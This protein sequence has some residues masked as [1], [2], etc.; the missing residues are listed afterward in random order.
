M[1]YNW[2]RGS[3]GVI[4]RRVDTSRA[5]PPADKFKKK[6]TITPATDHR[7][8]LCPPTDAGQH[9]LRFADD[10]R[11][12]FALQTA[13][14][15]GLRCRRH[16]RQGALG[17]GA[18]QADRSPAA[19]FG[20]LHGC[21]C[22][23]VVGFCWFR[24]CRAQGMGGERSTECVLYCFRVNRICAR[25]RRLID[26]SRMLCAVVRARIWVTAHYTTCSDK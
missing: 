17:H 10:F 26:N 22:G 19:R 14:V 24:C 7:S 18:V 15:R 13:A 9:V 11:T 1:P 23:W 25:T 2:R 21:R 4:G 3:R 20:V 12:G 16:Q 6:H 8:K 5:P